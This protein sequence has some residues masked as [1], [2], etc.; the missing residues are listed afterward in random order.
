MINTRNIDRIKDDI[1]LEFRKSGYSR[2]PHD[3]ANKW[4]IT[5]FKKPF[6]RRVIKLKFGISNEIEAIADKIMYEVS[7]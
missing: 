7:K 1:I 6:S 3:Y 5:N 2:T 4:F